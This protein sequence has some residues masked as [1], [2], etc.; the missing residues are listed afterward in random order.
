MNTYFIE[1][2]CAFKPEEEQNL[3]L[4]EKCKRISGCMGTRLTQFK[5]KLRQSE[6]HISV[7]W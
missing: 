1:C 7:K 3:A 6:E 4:K 2:L 5:R